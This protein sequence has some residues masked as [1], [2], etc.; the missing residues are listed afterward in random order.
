MPTWF[1]V[2]ACAA[3]GVV[4]GVTVAIAYIVGSLEQR[5]RVHS[6][7]LA[8]LRSQLDAVLHRLG[9][10]G[11]HLTTLEKKLDELLKRP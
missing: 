1:I 4:V 8:Q 11:I 6:L 5:V 2:F 10:I 3:L 7:D 9:V